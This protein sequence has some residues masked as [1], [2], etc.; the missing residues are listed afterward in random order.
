M[1]EPVATA[2]RHPRHR[3]RCARRHALRDDERSL[4]RLVK[5]VG[6]FVAEGVHVIEEAVEV[7]RV[8]GA[9]RVD[10]PPVDRVGH[11][12]IDSFREWPGQS[13]DRGG[14]AIGL[15]F[16][17][18]TLGGE[19]HARHHE[20]AVVR[21]GS[22]CGIHDEGAAEPRV[23]TLAAVDGG[24]AEGRPIV[25]G[26]RLTRIELHGLLG[27]SGEA[28]DASV[29]RIACGGARVQAVD[30]ETFAGEVAV[31]GVSDGDAKMG[32]RAH[33]DERPRYARRAVA[34]GEG[35]NGECGGTT[36]AVRKPAA[37]ARGEH[38]VHVVGV[39]PARRAAVVVRQDARGR[40][41]GVLVAIVGRRGC[42]SGEDAEQCNHAPR[43]AGADSHVHHGVVPAVEGRG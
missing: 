22:V 32:P 20:D 17:T 31:Q 41:C 23:V 33:A 40:R 16:R 14:E 7:H 30:H 42:T 15:V 19:H 27:T 18:F 13:I 24:V 39:I 25:I 4:I 38:N 34:L 1:H 21:N 26:S 29:Q 36:I 35:G 11:G 2:L 3:H 43:C 10:P 37:R 9:G 28:D 12:G 6:T 8:G 5:R